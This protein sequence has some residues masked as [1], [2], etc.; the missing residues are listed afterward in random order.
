MRHT[1]IRT[2][3]AI[4]FPPLGWQSSELLWEFTYR[5]KMRLINLWSIL[6]LTL[7]SIQLCSAREVIDG[8][9]GSF[10]EFRKRMR[11]YL[12]ERVKELRTIDDEVWLDIEKTMDGNI[13]LVYLPQLKSMIKSCGPNTAYRV[14]SASKTAIM[15]VAELELEDWPRFLKCYTDLGIYMLNPGYGETPVTADFE[16]QLQDLVET[17]KARI[18]GIIEEIVD[19]FILEVHRARTY[20]YSNLSEVEDDK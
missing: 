9:L 5:H 17:I 18:S 14:E 13:T 16:K 4:N 12:E 6:V 15:H 8:S 7:F 1:H 20:Q 2:R 10:K 3:F 11:L 19:K